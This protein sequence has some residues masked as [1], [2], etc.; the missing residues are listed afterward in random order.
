MDTNDEEESESSGSEEKEEAITQENMMTTES[1]ENMKRRK[2]RNMIR[3]YGASFTTAAVETMGGLGKEFRDLL[4][5]MAL[6]A[7]VNESG[8]EKKSSQV[9]EMQQL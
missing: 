9:L 4:D 2:Y 5:D 1:V 6:E 7:M 8:W 3:D